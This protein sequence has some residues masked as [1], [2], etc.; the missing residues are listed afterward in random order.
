M[1]DRDPLEQLCRYCGIEWEYRDFW[2]EEHRAPERTLRALLVAMG[3]MAEDADPAQVLAALEAQT[4]PLLPPVQV[5]REHQAVPLML[6]PE[7]HE[8]TIEWHLML[9]QGEHFSGECCPADLPPVSADD[10]RPGFQ[11]P[12]ELPLG[13]HRLEMSI[14]A[15]GLVAACTLIRVPQ[16][17][18]MP[19]ALAEGQRLWGLAVNPASLR[20]TRNW[21]IGDY[22][23]LRAT[24]ERAVELGATTLALT[25]LHAGF[26]GLPERASPFR[27]SNRLWF[28]V[29]LLDVEAIAECRDCPAAQER[30]ADNRFQARLRALRASD[31]LDYTAVADLK[32]ELL[33]LLFSHFCS[34]HLSSDS[35]RGQAFREFQ[36]RGGESLHQQ[37]LFD[38]LFAHFRASIPGVRSWRDWPEAY[39]NPHSPEVQVFASEHAERLDFYSYLQ[40]QASSQL[41]AV[42]E[43]ALELHMGIGVCQDFALSAHADGAEVWAQQDLYASVPGVAAPAD[44]FNR[45]GQ[46]WGLPLPI[47]G[48]LREQAYRSF[49]A[50]LRTS[51]RHA[52][53]IR[54]DHIMRLLALYW[55]P[56]EG[57]L[58]MG[59][60]VRF[61]LQEMLGILALESQR[62]Q[63]LV[64]GED[65]G[66]VR[67]ELREALRNA[68]VLG[69]QVL[70]WAKD[71]QGEFL[72][73][74]AY[75]AAGL[76]SLSTHDLP[77]LSGFWQGSELRLY[78]EL[79]LFPSSG[80]R[81]QL[82]TERATDRARLL[83]ALEQQNLLPPGIAVQPDVAMDSELALAVHRY[84]AR[85]RASIMLVHP[86]DIL[87][88]VGQAHIPGTGEDYPNWR[89]RLSLNWEEWQADP[90]LRQLSEA[91]NQERQPGEGRIQ[92]SARALPARG[93]VPRATYRWQLHQ[94]FN[95]AEASRWAAYL[96]RLGV[97]HAYASPYLQARPGSTHGYDIIDHQRIN[98]EIG[99]EAEFQHFCDTLR[100]QGLG[101]ILDIVPNHMGIMG[102]DNR[103]WLDV[104]ENGEASPYAAFFDIDWN[105]EKSE[106]QGKVLV[107][108]LGD[109]YGV[110]LE[111]RELVLRF[112]ELAGSFSI[113]YYEHRFP[114]DPATYPL[115]LRHRLERLEQRLEADHPA[116]AEYQSLA[117][118][119]ENLPSRQDLDPRQLAERQ[120]DKDIH[121]QHL[122]GLCRRF[123]DIGYFLEETV[124]DLNGIAGEALSLD[125]LHKL[126]DAQAYRLAY[127]RVAA[128]DINYR[129]FF[130]INNLAGLRMEEPGVFEASHALVLEL[131][132]SGRVD[133]LRIDHPD[134]L[135]DPAAYF[136]QLQRAFVVSG[137]VDAAPKDRPLYVVVE[138]ILAPF[139]RLPEEWPVQ[140]TT[141]YDFTN[142]VNGLLVDG[143]QGDAFEALYADFL[144]VEAA[145]LDFEPLLYACKKLIMETSLDSELSVLSNRLYRIAQ[146]DRRTRDFTRNGLRDALSEVVAA[147]PVY[148]TYVDGGEIRE[149]DQYYVDWALSIALKH[150]ATADSSIYEFIREVLLTRIAEGK[151]LGFRQQVLD[152]AMKFQQYTGPVMAK[153]MEDTS[154]YRYNRLSSLNEV[155]GEP[156]HFGVS[157]GSF[158]HA[159]GERQRRWPH[160]MLSSST[161][162]SKRSEDVR[163]RISVLSEFPEEWRRQLHRWS[164]LNAG[165]KR[166]L[167]SGPAPSA[168]DEYLLYQTLIGIW[169]ETMPDEVGRLALCQRLKGYMEKAV[170]EAKR[171]SSWLNPD[172]DYEEAVF[173]FIE[174]LL[175][176][177]ENN[178]FLNDFLP[179]QGQLAHFGYFNSLS[180]ALL[181]LTSPGV[182][183]IYQGNELFD[184]SLVDPDNRRAVDYP[185]REALL[186]ELET[187]LAVPAETQAER[188]SELLTQL[189][190]GRCKLLLTWR[191]LNLRREH[192][193][194]FQW[195]DYRSL[196]VSG[197]RAEHLCAFARSHEGQTLLVLAPRLYARLLDYQPGLPLGEVWDDTRVE[198]PAGCEQLRN[199]LTGERYEAT[200]SLELA[201]VLKHFP[202]GVL[203]TV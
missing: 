183:D 112:D 79:D 110:V 42:G 22:T 152:F 52:G 58:S 95:F 167:E 71:R 63:C 98:P 177:P 43:R 146:A 48:R 168:N 179:F 14:A 163:A 81:A 164:R 142:L 100:G 201:Q 18:Y 193:G 116:L 176:E 28:N 92:P 111:N 77:T 93:N 113:F 119:F 148:R 94:Q 101:Q 162:D 51:M 126:L 131:L 125:G 50:M 127:W 138:K 178:R 156:K 132:E 73:P 172:A 23:D 90:R 123:P 155:G 29:L 158:H 161:H 137:D 124:T 147:F 199:V 69:Q 46:R 61:D 55:V 20:S 3:V 159:N 197:S 26:P 76:V 49:V 82:I 191:V 185:H 139:E 15:L 180:Q 75:P 154:F 175:D 136:R 182:P 114:V 9:E 8:H 102:A 38:A 57:D 192:P 190:D 120:R 68:G 169:P 187:L 45:R 129:R 104:L 121:K 70:Y 41:A 96:G 7:A 74:E 88:D 143:D 118:A 56:P 150:R 10:S 135:Y 107:P 173:S 39:Q 53:A 6:A 170:R 19:V 145:E 1:R 40:W 140:G 84:L 99:S 195:G 194:L 60:Y 103:W 85:S 83:L 31:T 144:G 24:V 89:Q 87:G 4:P 188:V 91:I 80:V 37:V 72:P 13:Y 67:P 160:A 44:R 78:R 122:A 108:T 35:P 166:Q 30:L 32:L 157:V 130:D 203:L 33:E 106:L 202:L 109:Q 134:G 196:T 62:S 115:I 2:G 200:E 149:E 11:P 86:E 34:T 128:D 198:L 16:R 189:P 54:V 117:T 66:T 186:E 165:K 105:P 25:P 47:P 97:S 5:C 181:K 64:I 141:G 59:C 65:L 36:Q 151:A 184:F 12:Q 153:G 27:P 21:G 133:G 171:R 17:C 174:A